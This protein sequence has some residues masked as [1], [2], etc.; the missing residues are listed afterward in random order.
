METFPLP[1]MR[2][3]AWHKR[4][5][6][7]RVRMAGYRTVSVHARTALVAQ[8]VERQTC[9]L[10]VARSIRAEGYMDIKAR[11]LTPIDYIL[12]CARFTRRLD[13][14]SISADVFYR[15][16]KAEHSPIRVLMFEI[17]MMGIPYPSSVHFSRHKVGVEHFVTSSRPDIT[18]APRNIAAP[19]N[20][21]M[22]LNAQALI[23]MARRRLCHKA[24]TETREIMVQVRNAAAQAC[25]S[26]AHGLDAFGRAMYDAM[27]PDCQYRR[28]CYEINGCG[29]YHAE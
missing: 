8:L 6:E 1:T 4:P 28:R 7:W 23:T 12:D 17:D 29:R 20:H 14:K 3:Y 21:R 25:S 16:L 22:V 9:N 5:R 19:V 2:G 18:G 15:F 10:V 13:A 27:V 26:D 11:L 24:S